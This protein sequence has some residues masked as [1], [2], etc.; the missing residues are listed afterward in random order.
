DFGF[1]D[2]AVKIE[3]RTENRIGDDETCDKSEQILKN[4]LDAN[5]VSFELFPGEGAFYG[6]KIEFNLKDA[7]G[8]SWLCGTI[9][10]VF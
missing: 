8:R 7:I 2:F 4:A 3:L 9:Q 6:P 5:N 1:N 10:L